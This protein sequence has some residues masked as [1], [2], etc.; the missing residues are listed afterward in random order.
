MSTITL[1]ART[2]IA[3]VFGVAAFTKLLARSESHATFLEFGAG[4]R[5]SSI[6]ANLLAP[7][8]LAVAAAVMIV[9]TARSAAIAAMV[10]LAAFIAGIT[11]AL[12]RG[13]RP[14]CGC[15]GALRAAPIGV[16][17][18]AR[19][20]GLLAIA[21]VVAVS[22]PGPSV[23]GWLTSRDAVSLGIAAA[24]LYSVRRTTPH[25]GSATILG[26][27]VSALSAGDRAPEFT[28]TDG[29]GD[30]QTPG[31]LTAD[32][33]PLVLVFAS[34]G[35]GSC[36][37]LMARLSRLQTIFASTLGIAVVAIGEP[38]ST[39]RVFDQYDAQNVLTG[40]AGETQRAYGA[41]ITPAAVAV[42]PTGR[43]L[44]TVVVGTDAIE[45]LIRLTLR[46]F[47]PMHDPWSRTINA[48]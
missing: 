18:V 17:T 47:D 43:L 4:E 36:L 12:V 16:A 27:G 37:E 8:E 15:F 20:V 21:A 29:R 38:Q 48:A 31:S 25:D 5:L 30:T 2:L 9:P 24:G 35:C 1:A 10:L 3:I 19:N 41:L 33:R 45:D 44:G 34:A 11:N 7:A 42:A 28:L 39:R 13:R 23:D 32:G 6:G 26:G 46:R 40:L 22:G 14:E